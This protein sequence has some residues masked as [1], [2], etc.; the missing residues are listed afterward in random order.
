MFHGCFGRAWLEALLPRFE[1]A[2]GRTWPRLVDHAAE[3]WAVFPALAAEWALQRDNAAVLEH[4]RGFLASAEP[5]RDG[6]G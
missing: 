5:A 4:A 1:K 6:G 3:R 2:G